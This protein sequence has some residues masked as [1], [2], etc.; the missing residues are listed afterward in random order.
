MI[1]TVFTKDE[2]ALWGV[3]RYGVRQVHVYDSAK[4]IETTVP[5][6]NV[7]RIEL[8]LLEVPSGEPEPEEGEG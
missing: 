3:I 8:D 2:Q 5:L 6:P 7:E 1:G 4:Q